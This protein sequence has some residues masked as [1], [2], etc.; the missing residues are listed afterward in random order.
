MTTY[1]LSDIDAEN[2]RTL[3]CDGAV[4]VKANFDNVLGVTALQL[5]LGAIAQSTQTVVV[6][7]DGNV[8]IGNIGQL[9]P[10]V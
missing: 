9:D 1:I 5:L 10:I 8:L 7:E 2:Y 4:I 3:S 6:N